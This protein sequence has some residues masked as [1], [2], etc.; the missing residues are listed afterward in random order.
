VFP[1][2]IHRSLTITALKYSFIADKRRL[3]MRS[4]T[5]IGLILVVLGI[6]ALAVPGFTY[7]TTERVADVGFFAIDV[8]RP[9]TIFINPVV[10]VIA[11][12]VGIVLL[13]MGNRATSS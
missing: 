7:F 12:A 2:F 1:W 9:H 4:F 13:I 3:K 8:S 11:L 10:G 5:L 6:M